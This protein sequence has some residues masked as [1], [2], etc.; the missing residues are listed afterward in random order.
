M[1]DTSQ[2]ATPFATD[3]QATTVIV[4][5]IP[6]KRDTRSL[7]CRIQHLTNFTF[8]HLVRQDPVRTLQYEL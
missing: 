1:V 2:R 7:D 5:S 6:L 4:T 8:E 3:A